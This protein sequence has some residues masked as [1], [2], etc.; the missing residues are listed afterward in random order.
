VI[1]EHRHARP[2]AS[3]TD[4]ATIVYA[5]G[6]GL[7]SMSEQILRLSR[8]CS[9]FLF[10]AC[11]RRSTAVDLCLIRSPS[12][13]PNTLICWAGGGCCEVPNPEVNHGRSCC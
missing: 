6:K 9:S 5:I 13:R 1:E 7:G 10:W 2:A 8:H 4:N 11:S 3:A 12:S